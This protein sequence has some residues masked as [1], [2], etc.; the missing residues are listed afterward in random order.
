MH[1]ESKNVDNQRRSYK[2]YLAVLNQLE[3][4]L[5]NATDKKHKKLNP[6]VQDR[7]HKLQSLDFDFKIVS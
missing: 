6:M 3:T 2:A 5:I 7:I 1:K 4:L